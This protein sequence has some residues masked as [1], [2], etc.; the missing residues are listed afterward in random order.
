M[1]LLAHRTA[2]LH[3][4]M[5]RLMT[6]SVGGGPLPA[7]APGWTPTADITET[8]D[9]YLV[10]LDLLPGVR[11]RDLTVEVT[12]AEL[13]VDGELVEKE[14]AGRLRHRT[15]HVGRFAY[16][17]TLPRDIDT[18]HVSADLAGGVLTVR[19]PKTAAARRRRI[20]VNAG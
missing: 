17:A 14:K 9:A 3:Q 16:R 15:R 6:T 8:D 18:G 12:G 11:R 4:R 19:A 10:E 7:T 1:S 20:T 2:R 5:S 13:R